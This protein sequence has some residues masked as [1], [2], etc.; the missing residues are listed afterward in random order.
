[1]DFVHKEDRAAAEP[2]PGLFGFGHHR[3][4]LFGAGQDGAEGDEMRARRR[5]D[6][7][8]HRRLTGAGRTPQNDR[9]KRVA[10][11]RLAQ[12][13]TRGKELFLAEEILEGS[14]PH[15]LGQRRWHLSGGRLTLGEQVSG[16]HRMKPSAFR[17]SALR[18]RHQ[19]FHD[20]LTAK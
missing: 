10:L 20:L 13:P 5:G 15:P 3:P 11:D 7:S 16:G 18:S 17:R 14:W 4:N 2:A 19:R 9:L 6:E 12:R 8:C 1:M